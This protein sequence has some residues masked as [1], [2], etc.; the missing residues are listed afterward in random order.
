VFIELWFFILA[1]HE[2]R[3]QIGSPRQLE[4]QCISTLPGQRGL[5]GPQ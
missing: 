1:E 3:R 4:F 5:P 2:R